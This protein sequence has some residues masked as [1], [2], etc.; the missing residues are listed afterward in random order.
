MEENINEQLFEETEA[1][2]AE[3]QNEDTL[4]LRYNHQDVELTRDEATKFAQLGMQSE[5]TMK[6]L[7]YIAA[8]KGCGVGE[9]VKGMIKNDDEAVFCEYMDKT[10]GDA[11]L[12]EKLLDLRHKELENAADAEGIREKSEEKLALNKRITDELFKLLDNDSEITGIDDI[13]DEVLQNCA[14]NDTPLELEYYKYAFFN[15]KRVRDA[16]LKEAAAAKATA[17]KLYDSADIGTTPEIEAML[18]GIWGK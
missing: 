4:T 15:L 1:V 7:R 5:K 16:E 11:E 2:I 13:P 6:S 18:K 3:P 12:S 14:Q 8:A 9:L 17:G 10:G